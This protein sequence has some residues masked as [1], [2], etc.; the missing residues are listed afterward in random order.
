MHFECVFSPFRIQTLYFEC[1]FSPFRIQ[2]LTLSHSWKCLNFLQLRTLHPELAIVLL[3][4]SA[5]F[6]FP[7]EP[8]QVYRKP[9]CNKGV[10][11]Y[12]RF[13]CFVWKLLLFTFST[14]VCFQCQCL[15]ALTELLR[16]YA[17]YECPRL[18]AWTAAISLDDQ[19]S[20]SLEVNPGLWVSYVS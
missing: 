19:T 8:V 3:G 15:L 18:K 12:S 14:D 20:T 4:K 10:Y 1:D 2:S 13:T 16:N 6:L 11:T 9:P 7:S 17:A 5:A